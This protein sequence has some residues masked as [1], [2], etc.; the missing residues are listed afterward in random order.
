MGQV[1]GA[2][3]PG[4]AD[5]DHGFQAE[6]ITLLIA[7]ERQMPLTGFKLIR[8]ATFEG[9]LDGLGQRLDLRLGI[10]VVAQLEEVVPIRGRD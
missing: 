3:A 2:C 8:L 7:D 4:D 6:P 1:R 5:L 9:G 10:L